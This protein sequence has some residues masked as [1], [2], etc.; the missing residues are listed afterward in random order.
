MAPSVSS[1][2]TLLAALRL[3]DAAA[4]ATPGPWEPAVGISGYPDGKRDHSVVDVKAVGRNAWPAELCSYADADYI[5][6]VHP[7]L[8]HGLAQV[9]RVAHALTTWQTEDPRK[10]LDL[11]LEALAEVTEVALRE[12]EGDDL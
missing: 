10:G 12:R 8:G 6:L 5:S 7:G 11:L 3:E 1:E 2:R 9:L 4:L